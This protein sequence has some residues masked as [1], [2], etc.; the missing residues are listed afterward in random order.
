MRAPDRE[1]L[2]VVAELQQALADGREPQL[3]AAEWALLAAYIHQHGDPPDRRGHHKK[4][5][6]HVQGANRR[7]LRTRMEFLKIKLRNDPAE[8]EL[9]RA[10][11]REG[12]RYYGL[13]RRVAECMHDRLVK[14]GWEQIPSVE[15]LEN[16]LRRSTTDEPDWD[17]MV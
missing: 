1:L 17:P 13:N 4:M 3:S 8:R 9:K 2:A 5:T 11:R 14:A 7:M 6:R 16:I 10:M 12:G 15:A